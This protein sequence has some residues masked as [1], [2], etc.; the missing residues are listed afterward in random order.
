LFNAGLQ[1]GNEKKSDYALRME[2][3]LYVKKWSPTATPLLSDRKIRNSLIHMDEHLAK[4]LT[5]AN[6]G[7][8]IDSAIE[9]RDQ[10]TAAEHG[11]SIGFCRAYV[12][13][14][15]VIL[16]LDHEISMSGLRNEAARVLAEVWGI[17][18]KTGSR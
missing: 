4:A 1:R 14:D 10:F 3:A 17:D 18:A 7:W 9:R 13:A 15:D 12:A 11:L 16:H 5:R 2:R 6:T 8:L